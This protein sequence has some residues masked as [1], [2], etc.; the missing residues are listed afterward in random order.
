MVAFTLRDDAWALDLTGASGWQAILPAGESPAGRWDHAAAWDAAGDRL[1]LFGGHDGLGFLN[2]AWA[3]SL[4]GVADWVM[5]APTGALPVARRD[6]VA[7][8]DPVRRRMLVHGGYDGFGPFR[9]DV[10]ALSL[11]GEPAWEE[12]HPAGTPP[13]GAITHAGT[14]DPIRDRFVTFGGYYHNQTW[15]LPLAGPLAWAQVVPEGPL[16]PGRIDH[17]AIFD[18]ARD[19]VPAVRPN[20]A[21]EGCEVAFQLSAPARVRLLVTDAGGRRV[22]ELDAGRR[23]LLRALE[24]DTTRPRPNH[25]GSLIYPSVTVRGRVCGSR[26]PRPRRGGGSRSRGAPPPRV[27]RAHPR[28]HRALRRRACRS[29][30]SGP[31]GR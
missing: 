14:W 6:H 12:L 8:Y 3:L 15:A 24:R 1:L 26:S 2:D 13:D 20:P 11:E 29:P 31:A 19:L 27:R 25:P 7:V 22:R 23:L 9:N 17:T 10:W 16:P 5:L 4:A 18:A 28:L 21:R 30:A